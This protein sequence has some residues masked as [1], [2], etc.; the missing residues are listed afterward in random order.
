M[1]I[2]IIILVILVITA[3]GLAFYLDIFSK[4][5]VIEKT[6]GPYV[7]IYE[8]YVGNYNTVSTTMDQVYNAVSAEQIKTTRGFGIYLDDPKTTPKEQLRSELG[9][10]LE[11]KDYNRREDLEQKN[12]KIK[13]FAAQQSV[14]VEFPYKNFLSIIAGVIKVYPAIT[15]YIGE[16]GYQ[17]NFIMEIYDEPAGKI[18]YIMPVKKL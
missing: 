17:A 7:L 15:D 13:D 18:Y 1:K 6:M 11:E 2:L 14:V 3:S 16:R 9:V 8:P 4:V 10:I 12:F 5:Q